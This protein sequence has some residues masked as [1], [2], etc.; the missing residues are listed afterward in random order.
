MMPKILHG[1]VAR[2]RRTQTGLGKNPYV[3][4]CITHMA[5]NDAPLPARM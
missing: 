2:M 3:D 1:V 5:R 4:L